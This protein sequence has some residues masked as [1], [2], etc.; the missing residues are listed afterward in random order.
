MLVIEQTGKHYE[1]NRIEIFNKSYNIICLIYLDLKCFH[2]RRQ[3]SLDSKKSVKSPNYCFSFHK[4]YN[5]PSL[6]FVRLLK[7]YSKFT[8]RSISH[9][10]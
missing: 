9:T 3:N 4:F 10:F 7:F 2:N 1:M 5:K 8:Y 6:D